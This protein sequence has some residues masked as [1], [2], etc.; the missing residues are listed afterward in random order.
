MPTEVAALILFLPPFL[1]LLHCAPPRMLNRLASAEVLSSTIHSAYITT[2]HRRRIYA[3][4]ARASLPR[5]IRELCKQEITGRFYPL[6]SAIEL[7]K[8]LLFQCGV[9]ARHRFSKATSSASSGPPSSL[10]FQFTSSAVSE[11][12]N[13]YQELRFQFSDDACVYLTS[14]FRYLSP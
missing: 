1:V 11:C 12:S 5:G 7:V 3:S 9:S 4:Y 6:G 13:N 2:Y 8:N 14:P 10:R